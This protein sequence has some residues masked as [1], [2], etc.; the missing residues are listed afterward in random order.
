MM[1]KEKFLEI[2]ELSMAKVN[3]CSPGEK[4]ILNIHLVTKLG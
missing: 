4:V 3:L 1:I 2:S